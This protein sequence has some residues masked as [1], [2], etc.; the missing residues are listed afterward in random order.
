MRELLKCSDANAN[1]HNSRQTS[2]DCAE[3]PQTVQAID[4]RHMPP[5]TEGRCLNIHRDVDE[6]VEEQHT[7][8]A[9]NEHSRRSREPDNRQRAN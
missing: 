6:D 3:T 9:D 4:D 8:Q 7:H 5:G 2:T 1:Q